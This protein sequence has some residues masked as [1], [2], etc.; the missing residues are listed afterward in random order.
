MLTKDI[1]KK[2]APTSKDEIVI[3]LVEYLN[4]HMSKYDVDNYLRVCHFLAQAAH[5]SAS[6]RTLEEYASG[7]AYEGRKDLG[8]THKGDGIRYKGRG[9][10]QLTGRANYAKIGKVIGIDLENNPELAEFPEV[11]VLTALEYWK[12]RS[13]NALADKDDVEGIT[14]KINGGL[15]GFEDRKKYLSK[16]KSILPKNFKFEPEKS[17]LSIKEEVIIPV[18]QEEELPPDPIDPIIP[19]IVVARK[20]ESS[21][22]IID[23]QKMLNKKGANLFVDGIFGSKTE[24]AV[25]SFQ[26][27]YGLKVTGTIDTDTLNKL[28]V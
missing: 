23:L 4:K 28:M 8:N 11:S 25:I 13:L 27:K 26:T 19:P 14:R 17:I 15:N 3:P 21:F 18:V 1:I 6:F 12:S 10:F 24:Q 22:Y 16:I 20:G 5:E 2:L 7:E 9:I